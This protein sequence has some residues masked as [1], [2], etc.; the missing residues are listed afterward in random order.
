[1]GKLWRKL[2]GRTE[3]RSSKGVCGA[4][5]SALQHKVCYACVRARVVVRPVSLSK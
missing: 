2:M 1:M 3:V 5:G 4:C